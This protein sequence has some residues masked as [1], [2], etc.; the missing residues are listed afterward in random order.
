MTAPA[1]TREPDLLDLLAASAASSF[2]V[3]GEVRDAWLRGIQT[4]ADRDGD[5]D[6]GRVRD[7]LEAQGSTWAHS[8][9]SGATVTSLVRL[10]AAEWTGAMATLGNAEQRAG[11]RLVK[12]YRL[13]C[14]VW[15]EVKP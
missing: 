2:T 11:S 1:L 6:S 3:P 7:W 8:S 10:G 5:W 9:V 12:R 4:V 13:T 14:R 15:P